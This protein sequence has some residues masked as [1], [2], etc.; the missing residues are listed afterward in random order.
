MDSSVI[1][2]AP[3]PALFIEAADGPANL[4]AR[5]EAG[6]GFSLASHEVAIRRPLADL[7]EATVTA[8]AN[9]PHTERTY[10]RAIGGF[11]S[12]LETVHAALFSRPL[13]TRFTAGPRG[14]VTCDYGDTPAAVLLL[15]EAPLLDTYRRQAPANHYH[16]A[17]TFLAVAYRDKVLTDDQA[18]AL[19]IV[20]YQTR[21]RPGYAPAGR[22]LSV[23]E[24]QALRAGVDT[25]TNAGKRDLALLDVMLFCG[26]R[27]EEVARLNLADFQPDQG[28]WVM[29]FQG[30]GDKARKLIVPRTLYNS[31]SAWLGSYGPALG[32]NAPVF[33]RVNKA[34][35]LDPQHL[36]AQAVANIVVAAGFRA[37][38][39]PARGAHRLSPHDLRRTFARRAYD[40]GAGLPAIQVALGHVDPKT[41]ARYIGL[42]EEEGAAVTELVNYG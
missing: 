7:V 27:R 5:I 25:V 3:S 39:A 35:R 9:S 19:G 23:T 11:I 42:G 33:V 37:R 40:L 17:R 1:S 26:L 20:P 30:K 41:T 36:S 24:V 28:R 32:D 21:T 22:R 2:L 14:I 38:L 15:V 8:A 18:R 12:L 4:I 6:H 29:V 31:L 16:A 10:R 34:D 13:V